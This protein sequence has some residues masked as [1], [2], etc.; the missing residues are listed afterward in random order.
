[1]I[2]VNILLT[3]ADTGTV[4][5]VA[6]VSVTGKSEAGYPEYSRLYIV[7]NNVVSNR[8]IAAAADIDS[9]GI[10]VNII[11][12]YYYSGRRDINASG[13][14]NNSRSGTS[15]T[16][17]IARRIGFCRLAWPISVHFVTADDIISA[18]F[19]VDRIFSHFFRADKFIIFN[20]YILDFCPRISCLNTVGSDI[21]EVAAPYCDICRLTTARNPNSM[22]SV[23]G[24]EGSDV[25]EAAVFN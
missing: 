6:V 15:R 19:N 2:V 4:G 7:M 11:A 16:V 10:I 23:V 5:S 12:A 3:G 9:V 22:N 14:H 20:S 8:D 18:R 25:I 17:L 24:L 21:V 1:M 13:V